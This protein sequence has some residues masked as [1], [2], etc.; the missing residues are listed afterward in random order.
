MIHEYDILIL[1]AGTPNNHQSY[2]SVLFN[3]TLEKSRS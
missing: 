1:G 2:H 3:L